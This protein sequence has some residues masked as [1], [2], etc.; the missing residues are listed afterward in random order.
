MVTFLATI[1]ATPSI[2]GAVETD[3]DFYGQ[4]GVTDMATDRQTRNNIYVYEIENINGVVYIGG[5]FQKVVHRDAPDR[6]IDQAFIVAF[7][8][9][10][11]DIISSFRPEINHPVYAISEHPTTGS[12]LVGGEFTRV[13]G[14]DQTALVALDPETGQ[15]DPSFTGYVSR[16]GGARR[17]IVRGIDDDGTNIYVGGSF[18]RANS[19]ASIQYRT[20]VAKFD[21]NGNVDP[22]WRVNV[23]GGGIWDLVLST[24]K[25]RVIFGGLFNRVNAASRPGI[26]MVTASNVGTLTPAFPTWQSVAAYC[27]AGYPGCVFVYDLDVQDGRL[28]VSGAEHFSSLHDDSTGQRTRLWN[29]TNDTQAGLLDGDRVWRTRHGNDNTTGMY[30]AHNLHTNLPEVTTIARVAT[31][32]GG[33]EIEKGEND[34][35]WIGGAIGGM[36][37]ATSPGTN[38][39]RTHHVGFMCPH[40][41]VVPESQLNINNWTID[42]GL[43]IRGFHLVDKGRTYGVFGYTPAPNA[44]HHEVFLDGEF[45][46]TDDDGSFALSHLEPDRTYSVKVR[47]TDANGG[48]HNTTSTLVTETAGRGPKLDDAAG[49]SV[50]QISDYTAA[51]H[52]GLANDERT[53]NTAITSN[54]NE[55][56][57]QIDLGSSQPLENLDLW[58]RPGVPQQTRNVHVL[59]SDQPFTSDSLADAQAQSSLDVFLSGNGQYPATVDLDTTGRYV[60]LQI[61]DTNYLSIG[62]VDIWGALDPGPETVP[63]PNP[64]VIPNL[65]VH[66]FELTDL[67]YTYGVFSYDPAF[68]AIRHDVYLDDVLVGS[69]N[70]GSFAFSELAA[71]TT[72]VVELRAVDA[73]GSKKSQ[74]KTFT[75]NSPPRGPQLDNAAG[76]TVAQINDYTGSYPAQRANDDNTSNTSITKF[77]N[78][79][80]WQ[81]DLGSSQSLADLELWAR[82]G[83]PQQTRNIHVLVSDQPFTSDSL[84]DA[85]AQSSVDVF[86]SG[87]GHYPAAVNLNTT[88][89]YI[90]LQT[91]DSNYLSIGEV[92]LWG[93]T[94]PGPETVPHPN[95]FVIGVAPPPGDLVC[96]LELNGGDVDVKW[97]GNTPADS[98]VIYRTPQGANRFWR[99]KALAGD[100]SFTD[101][102]DGSN[103]TY[104]I[105]E[106]IGAQF[107]RVSDCGD[108]E[109]PPPPPPSLVCDVSAANG[110]AVVSWTG[111]NAGADSV[112]VFRTPQ[113][114]GTFW[115]GKADAALGNFTD[116]SQPGTYDYEVREKT[117]QTVSDPIECGSVDVGPPEPVQPMLTCTVA[118]VRGEAVLTFAGQTNAD[119]VVI[120]RSTGGGQMFWRGKVDAAATDFTDSLRPATFDYEIRER[121]GAINTDPV[122]CGTVQG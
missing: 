113:G 85:Q 84:A 61:S 21:A 50:S 5:A 74:S 19:G 30:Y 31:G 1:S 67:G 64:F 111:Q 95:P 22:A 46:G 14:A 73:N 83:I 71:A 77:G 16:S 65:N 35:V 79:A 116:G 52:A 90:R 40:G 104:E 119:S 120:F 26:A 34:C 76:V 115:R 18:G 56:W 42:P 117:G 25:Q 60:R 27:Y 86:L 94:N 70:D 55:G 68:D 59:V 72:Y 89:R 44:I 54:H 96:E 109:T 38:K 6:P 105:V 37:L 103:Y 82:Q 57:W 81:I 11:G 98:V 23:G 9:A 41:T 36:D 93:A 100:G 75:T 47:A 39:V 122:S 107:G 92:N 29:E 78:E 63:H 8:A 51:Y 49:I 15:T 20:N 66:N 62:E 13:N 53:N 3:W 69:N 4:W 58:A 102:L 80:W 43:F 10:S 108:I 28:L 12:I 32:A 121:T 88:G 106:R 97:T 114:Q 87:D 17:A 24:D 33:F 2:A 45:V 118:N 112:I 7:D 91:N 99:G 48:V 110:D 101:T